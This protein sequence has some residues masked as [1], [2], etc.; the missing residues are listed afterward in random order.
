MFVVCSLCHVEST[1]GVSSGDKAKPALLGTL[2]SSLHKLKDT[3]NG[4]GAFFVFGDV[5][6]RVTGTWRLQFALYDYH[7]A[8][9]RYVFL[10][11]VISDPFKVVSL[12]DFK[13]LDESTYL[14]RAFSDQG[15]RL[16]LRKEPRAFKY[17]SPP[18]LLNLCQAEGIS[19]DTCF[20]ATT[21]SA[22]RVK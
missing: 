14:S 15:V 1:D 18:K 6:I 13:G 21:E 10:S 12:K 19:A 7:K 20:L 11:Q 22:Q 8:T 2:A 17:D 4:D 9:M 5:S 16:R 3:D